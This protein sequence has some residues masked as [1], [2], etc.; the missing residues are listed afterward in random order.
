MKYEELSANTVA[1][2]VVDVDLSTADESHNVC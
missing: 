2:S 1:S